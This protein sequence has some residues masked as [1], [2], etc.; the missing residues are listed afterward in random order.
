MQRSTPARP[1][2]AAK[3]PIV[4]TIAKTR[5]RTRSLARLGLLVGFFVSLQGAFGCAPKVAIEAP[6]EPIVINM[7]IKVE[8][9]IR[10]SVD[11]DLEVLF[12]EEEEIF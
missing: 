2:A 6:K 10:V 7:N 1:S 9:E 5:V 8:H 4:T 12:E 3:L 11:R